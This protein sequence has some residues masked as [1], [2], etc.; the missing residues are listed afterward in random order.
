LCRNE[1][2]WRLAWLVSCLEQL[3]HDVSELRQAGRTV[4]QAQEPANAPCSSTIGWPEPCTSCQ[5]GSPFTSTYVTTTSCSLASVP[6][7]SQHKTPADGQ[8]RWPLASTTADTLGAKLGG[9][10]PDGLLEGGLR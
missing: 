6:A 8:D 1:R 9:E 7:S 2:I 4:E 3:L 10:G 5:V